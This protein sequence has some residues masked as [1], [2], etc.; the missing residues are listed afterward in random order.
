ML[1]SFKAS[2]EKN[3]YG[4]ILMLLSSVFVCFGQL[5]WKIALT[6]GLI[7]IFL[8]FVLYGIG[9][10]IMISAY[11]YGSLSVLH[12]MLSINYILASIIA[13]FILREPISL[14]KLTGIIIIIIGVV[15]I[16]GGDE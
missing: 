16:G 4:I 7:Y 3:K 10:M 12:P 14:Q 9:A 8:G 13:Y 5:F 6:S 15:L 11:R 1:N 2:I